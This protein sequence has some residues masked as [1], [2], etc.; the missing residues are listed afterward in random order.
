MRR[1]PGESVADAGARASASAGDETVG[2]GADVVRQERDFYLRLLS[3]GAADDLDRFLEETLALVVEITGAQHGYIELR[4]REGDPA[5]SVAHGYAAD[6]VAE[7]RAHVSTGIIAEAIATGRTVL[8][9]S[10]AVDERF[11]DRGSVRAGAIASVLCAPIGDAAPLGVVYLQADSADQFDERDRARVELL[12]ARVAPF[13][14]RLLARREAEATADPLAELRA[15]RRFAGIVGRSAAI[16]ATVQQAAN[17]ARLDVT[18]LLTGDSG[19]GK[20]QLA[21]AIHD[22]SPRARH[23]FVELNCA[24]LPETLIENELFGAARGG[25]STAGRPVVG[26]I[27]AAE[28]GTLFLDEVAELPLAAQ[29][30]LLQFFQS[31]AY[32]PL[33]ASTP[34]SADV[35][36][37]TATNA[38][39]EERVEQGRF[40]Q[41]LLYRLQVVPLRVPSLAERR[42]DVRELAQHF[43]REACER[44]GLPFLRL[45]PGALAEVETAEWPGN[46]RQLAHAVEAGAIQAALAGLGEVE[47]AH[48]FPARAPASALASSA[49]GAGGDPAFAAFQSFQSATREFQ[50]ELVRRT[51]EDTEWSIAETARRLDL[52][53]QY[54][55]KLIKRFD[56]K[57]TS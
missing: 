4:D 37:V 14:D 7:L 54:V 26:K 56:L 12:G 13:A 11:R 27:E 16:A 28:H 19:V 49:G 55:H 25:H 39:L 50:R 40:R 52:A 34:R 29:A 9:R 36:I 2:P 15:Q 46:V 51:L 41:D 8:T 23:P 21:R 43:C 5:W 47:A 6:E 44:N 33:G 1:A 53:R 35:R 3:L 17:L 31:R 20:S 45:S 18:I 24:A 30:K 32:Y 22:E 57:R 42:D 48:L 10:A 38:D